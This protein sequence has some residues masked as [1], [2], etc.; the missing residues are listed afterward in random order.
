LCFFTGLNN[1]RENG[2]RV[3]KLAD[4]V[5]INK[6]SNEVAKE[7]PSNFSFHD[8]EWIRV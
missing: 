2:F 5:L 4:T 6:V 3:M 8:V 7:V 1:W